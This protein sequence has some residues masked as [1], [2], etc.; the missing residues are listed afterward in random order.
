MGVRGCVLWQRLNLT[1][2]SS[3]DDYPHYASRDRLTSA[4]RWTELAV[5]KRTNTAYSYIDAT[6]LVQEHGAGGLVPVCLHVS[7]HIRRVSA[8]TSPNL[9][10]AVLLEH[11]ASCSFLERRRT[12]RWVAQVIAENLKK[13]AHAIMVSARAPVF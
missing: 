8:S 9:F 13:L 12:R 4:C 6:Q 1:N 7:L 10:D 11:S 3:Y 5:D 2:V